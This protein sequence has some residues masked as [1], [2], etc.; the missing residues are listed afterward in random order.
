MPA[1][2]A[3]KATD[4]AHV[5]KYL[6][7][8]IPL[9][10]KHADWE[11]FYQSYRKPGYVPGFEIRQ[12]IGAGCFGV[13]FKARKESIAKDYAIKF[14]KVDDEALQRRLWNSTSDEFS[15]TQQFHVTSQLEGLMNELTGF[16]LSNELSEFFNTWSES[17]NARGAA[18]SSAARRNARRLSSAPC[19]TSISATRG[20]APQ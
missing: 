19:A 16:D 12:K 6:D 15:A 3:L 10:Y 7:G 14:L 13:V 18:P 8:K 17:A 1:N 20:V 5:I 11:A 4:I 2:N 9:Q